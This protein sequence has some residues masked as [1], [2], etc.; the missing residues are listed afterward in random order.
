MDYQAHISHP[1]LR[2]GRTVYMLNYTGSNDFSFNVQSGWRDG[3]RTTDA[4]LEQVA[5]LA[6]A[7]PNLLAALKD[8]IDPW[9]G[10]NEQGVRHRT[11]ALQFDRIMIARSAIAKAEGR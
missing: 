1:W 6:Q 4:E 7:A 10:F 2:E 3:H 11:D 5:M 8:M 9:D